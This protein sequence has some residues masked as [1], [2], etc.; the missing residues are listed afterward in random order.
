MSAEIK[1]ERGYITND[2]NRMN[3]MNKEEP[4]NT[5]KG[6]EEFLKSIFSVFFR[7]FRG[8]CSLSKDKHRSSASVQLPFPRLGGRQLPQGLYPLLSASSRF[9]GI[10]D[11]LSEPHVSL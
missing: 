8:L 6:T 2:T 11:F 9:R 5:R 7:A 4:R 1:G 3:R 10:R